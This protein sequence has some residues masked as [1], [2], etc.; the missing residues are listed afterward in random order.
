MANKDESDKA[1]QET[2]AAFEEFLLTAPKEIREHLRRIK[3]NADSYNE[4]LEAEFPD[5]NDKRMVE[6]TCT[7]LLMNK[8]LRMSGGNMA[9]V[10]EDRFARALVVMLSI[11]TKEDHARASKI[12]EFAKEMTGVVLVEVERK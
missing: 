3:A 7:F 1:K 8:A 10:L 11:Y 9:Q 5:D 12:W 6:V 2:D 4:R